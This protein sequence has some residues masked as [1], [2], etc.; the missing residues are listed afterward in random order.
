MPTPS[1]SILLAALAILFTRVLLGILLEYR[2]YFPADFDASAFL[3]GRRYTFTGFYPAFFYTHV[4]SGPVAIVLASFLIL[5]GGRARLSRWHRLA[6]RTL[7]LIVLFLLFPSGLVMAYQ[8]YAGPPAAAGFGMLSLL[9]AAAALMAAYHARARRFAL[10]RRWAERCFL[11]L[12]SPLILRLI[13]GVVIVMD[14]ESLWTYRLNAWLS[15]LGP[16]MIY[17][18]VKYRKTPTVPV[19]KE[20]TK[21]RLKS[22]SSRHGFTWIELV[23]VI[24]VVIVLAALLLPSMRTASEAARRMQCQNNLKQIGLAIQNYE[25]FHKHLPSAMA[26]TGVG[27][28]DLSGNANRLSGLV[29]LLPYVEPSRLW[30]QI[31]T[32]STIDGVDYPA[33]GPTPWV[34][35]YPPWQTRLP[36]LLCPSWPESDTKLARTNY[37]FCIGDVSRA[38]HAP[39][40]QR[41]AFAC[42]LFTKLSSITDGISNTIALAEI[43]NRQ[44]RLLSG[45][46]AINQPTTMLDA[47]NDC[48]G[49]RDIRRPSQYTPKL[50]LSPLGR[51]ARWVD[52]A[53]PYGLFATIL[54]PNSPSCAIGGD[55]AVDGIYSSGS[56]HTGGV[57]VVLVDGSVR[58][59]SDIIDTGQATHSPPTAEQFTQQPTPSPFGVWGAFGTAA[60]ADASSAE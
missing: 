12:L 1:K 30:D 16:L 55:E 45:Q 2:W 11:L 50:P 49:L 29:A 28:T 17:E 6:G 34:E 47:P 13:A 58:F 44:D 4:L 14:I 39:Q 25:E 38:V 60:A 37:A 23:V 21:V 27:P 31:S 32:A 15:W 43:G 26:G 20:L 33:M 7:V 48:M 36:M 10:H 3:S 56:L 5:S 41:G 22:Q 42:G 18:V 9:T 8:A 54:P 19:S 57:Q 51:G 24:L 46:A 53:A 59:I 35:D 40:A 52:G